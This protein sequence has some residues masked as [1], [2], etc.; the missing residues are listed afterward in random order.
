MEYNRGSSYRKDNMIRD[1]S[2]SRKLSAPHLV[3]KPVE[4]GKEK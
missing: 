3:I 2:P 4:K 1:Y